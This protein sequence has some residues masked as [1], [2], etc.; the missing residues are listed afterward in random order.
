MDPSRK[1]E[2]TIVDARTGTILNSGAMAADQLPASFLHATT[3]HI[4]DQDWSVVKAEPPTRPEYTAT[5]RLLLTLARIERIDPK[6]IL[7]SLPSINDELPGLAGEADGSETVLAEDDWRQVE[8]VHAEHRA[9]IDDELSDIRA[10]HEAHRQQMAFDK[11]HVRRRIS[12]PLSPSH[13]AYRELTR[14]DLAAARSLRLDGQGLR[15]DG[16]FAHVLVDGWLLYGVAKLESVRV[17]ALHWRAVTTPD[18]KLSA[19]ERLAREHDLLLVDW[20]RCAVGEPTRPSFAAVVTAV[21]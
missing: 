16:G 5:G 20:C 17:L 21:E 1:V 2:V 7:F 10:I 13:L 18:D 8:F 3:I 4:G 15:I 19:I 6:T 12:D 9:A 11:I 14:L